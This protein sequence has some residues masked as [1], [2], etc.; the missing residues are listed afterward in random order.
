MS[1]PGKSFTPSRRS[2]LSG[3]AAVLGGTSLA[4]AASEPVR[5]P[6]AAP[7]S[8]ATAQHQPFHGIH[9]SGIVTPRPATGLVAAFDVTATSLDELERLFRLLSERIAFLMQGG[10]APTADPGFPP[11]DSGI[12]GPV[13]APDNLTVTL[14]LGASLFDERFGLGSLKPRH[15]QRMKRFRNDAL[16][17]ALCHGDLL[18][19]FCANTADTSIHALRDILKNAPDLLLLRW[20]QEG[21]VPVLKPKQ[22]E[23][24]ESARNLLGFRDGT[25]NPDAAD[26]AL[27]DHLVWVQSGPSEPDWAAN[28]SYQVVRIIRNFVER[29]D[30]TP[31]G[32]QEAIMGREKASGAPFG[33]KRNSTPISGSPIRAG[34]RR[35][36]A[37]CC[38]APST[39]PTVSPAPGS[40]T[41]G[42][43]SSASSRI[44][45]AASSPCR[46]GSMASR[47][48]NTSSPSAAAIS[49][50]CPAW[51]TPAAISAPG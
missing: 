30:R 51:P 6:A 24:A 48:R 28:G 37:A 5:N 32:E 31:L 16:D 46:S 40:S 36:R 21:T 9:Q 23:P 34:R 49:S 44:S 13:I 8:D 25:A 35:K 7:E 45:S 43:S 38:A 14:A 4:Q 11:P 29:W 50:L 27:M 10:P 12:L 22:G 20:K 1:G 18:L 15:L 47:W 42:C 17:G 26:T 33:G 3:G 2:L 39:T 19:Q 41:W